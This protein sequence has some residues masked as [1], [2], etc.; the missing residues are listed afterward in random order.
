[1]GGGGSVGG[2]RKPWGRSC[3]SVRTHHPQ[4]IRGEAGGLGVQGDLL[5]AVGT[6]PLGFFV[7][8]QCSQKVFFAEVQSEE[9]QV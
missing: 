7:P 8:P 4:P 6:V 2:C 1:M 5:C 9:L 3:V